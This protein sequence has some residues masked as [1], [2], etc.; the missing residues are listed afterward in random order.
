MFVDYCLEKQLEGAMAFT[1]P[2][3]MLTMTM[4]VCVLNLDWKTAGKTNGVHFFQQSDGDYDALR[5]VEYCMENI[6]R[7]QELPLLPTR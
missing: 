4:L 7:E 6:W 1:S 5:L 2:S 3:N